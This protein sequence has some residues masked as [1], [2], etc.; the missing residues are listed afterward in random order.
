MQF[1]PL[2]VIVTRQ[3]V[4]DQNI[5]PALMVLNRLLDSPQIARSFMEKVDI[6]FHGYDDITWELFEISEVRGYVHKLD[7]QFPYWLFFLSKQC[8]GLQCL[9]FCN[10]LP[11][12]TNEGKA[13]HHPKQLYDLLMSRWFPAMNHVAEFA[14]VREDEI[15]ALTERAMEYFTHGRM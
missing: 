7:D 5:Q 13:E 1:D 9:M 11:F 3:E 10:L 6:G 4:I 15:E 12:L 14:G 8:L 2:C